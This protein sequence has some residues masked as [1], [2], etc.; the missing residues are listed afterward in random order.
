MPYGFSVFN[1]NKTTYDASEEL[2]STY[3]NVLWKPDETC[4]LVSG[5]VVGADEIFNTEKNAA[6]THCLQFLNDNGWIIED[7]ET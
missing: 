2:Q 1:I 4:F 3:K 5:V 7:E 6:K